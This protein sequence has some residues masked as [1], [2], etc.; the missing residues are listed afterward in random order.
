MISGVEINWPKF[1]WFWKKKFEMI[2]NHFI[3]RISLSFLL[4]EKQLANFLTWYNAWKN[5]WKVPNVFKALQKWNEKKLDINLFSFSEVN[6]FI[7]NVEKWPNI[8]WKFCDVEH[9]K[10]FIV[11]LVIFYLYVWKC[12]SGEKIQFFQIVFWK[13]FINLDAIFKIDQA[14]ESNKVSF[15]MCFLDVY[16]YQSFV[17]VERVKLVIYNIVLKKFS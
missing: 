9:G 6:P 16:D 12:Q 4:D 15:P 7:N 10:I 3:P 5:M 2:P 14:K 11:C 8:L 13:F 1:A 17:V